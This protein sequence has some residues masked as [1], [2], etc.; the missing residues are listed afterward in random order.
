MIRLSRCK[1]RGL[2]FLLHVLYLY[3]H[4]LTCTPTSSQ[5]THSHTPP[6]TIH[7]LS[8]TNAHPP[9]STTHTFTHMH[10]LS[11]HT[12]LHNHHLPPNT[13][14]LQCTPIPSHHTHMHTASHHMHKH[15]HVHPYFFSNT[16][17]EGFCI[18]KKKQNFSEIHNN[19][20]NEQ[21]IISKDFEA[22]QA[23]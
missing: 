2:R 4:T 8:H 1:Q 17:A 21:K 18:Q 5:H 19:V 7:T 3:E 23:T 14:T 9:Y 11:Q 16:E 22:L 12:F 10:T 15:I 20:H 6:P 13:H